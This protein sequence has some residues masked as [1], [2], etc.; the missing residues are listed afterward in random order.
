MTYDASPTPAGGYNRRVMRDL[1]L[2][3]T[4]TKR[5]ESMLARMGATG[6]GLHEKA[7]SVSGRLPPGTLK[8]LRFIATVRNKLLHDD[9][10]DR[11]DDKAGFVRAAAEAEK[12][13]RAMIGKKQLVPRWVGWVVAVLLLMLLSLGMAR[14]LEA[15]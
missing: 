11:L 14:Y 9:G 15:L 7:S 8:R 2:V 4:R 3:I 5:L 6:R 12:E 1:K 10:Y 13:L